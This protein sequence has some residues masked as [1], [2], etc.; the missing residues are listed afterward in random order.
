[1]AT[2]KDLFKSQQKRI[3][4]NDNI[5]IESRGLINPPRGAALLTSSPGALADLIGNQIG[6]ALG[7]SANR[8]TDTIFDAKKGNSILN[9]P[10][11]LF[12]TQEGLKYAVK[13]DTDYIVKE[14]PAPGSIISSLNSGASSLGGAVANLA[15]NAVTKGG[16]KNLAE[17]LKKKK[18]GKTI[19]LSDGTEL[20]IYTKKDNFSKEINVNNQWDNNGINDISEISED[21]LVETIKKYTGQNIVP[22]LFKKYGTAVTI[23]FQST[24]SGLSEDI[25]PEWSNFKYVGS[26]FKIYRYQ[27][28]ER[29]LKF[30]LK[31][32]YFTPN[33]KTM[34]ISKLNFLK[35]LAFPYEE[36]SEMTY[37]NDKQSSQYAFSP[38]LFYLTIGDM[39]KNVFGHLDNISFQVQDNVSW[40]TMGVED[41]DNYMYPSVIETQISMKIIE[42]HKV[43]KDG[44]IT[45]YKY[46]FD[47]RDTVVETPKK[48]EQ[49]KTEASLSQKTDE[50]PGDSTY[51]MK[52]GYEG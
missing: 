11:S 21:K 28:V 32:Y 6:G 34:M 7:G 43:V 46:D 10:I 36:I 35:S 37:G 31:L 29:T 25:Q 18:N 24:L 47:G 26:P 1:M 12:K 51:S 45:R 3:Y 4:G 49:K 9:K 5:R 14:S 42:N 17:K 22:I 38:N 39:Y 8:P 48:E 52:S 41:V 20:P 44:G 40:P 23:P 33:Q 16:L 27:G 2:I 30:N 19:T 50:G 13:K 15:I